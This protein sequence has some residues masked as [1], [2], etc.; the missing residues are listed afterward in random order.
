M[1]QALQQAQAGSN[2]ESQL[3]MRSIEPILFAFKHSTYG[4]SNLNIVDADVV[5]QFQQVTH[6]RCLGDRTHTLY[7]GLHREH[8]R[9]Q[10]RG[11][12]NRS[13]LDVIPLRLGE[14]AF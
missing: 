12:W 10:K 5:A 3:M 2:V 4:A 8:L 9:E 14:P 11:M 13:N 7:A 1:I 6:G